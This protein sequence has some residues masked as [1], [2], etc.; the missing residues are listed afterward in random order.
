MHDGLRDGILADLDALL[1]TGGFANG[2][3]V[4]EFEAAYADYNEATHCVGVANGLDGLRLSLQGLDIGRGDEVIVPA[5]TFVATWEAVSQVGATPVPVDV[6]PSDYCMSID[7]AAAAVTSRTRCLLPVDL[8]GQLGDLAALRQLADRH[9]L[10]LVEDACQ[11]HG[12]RRDGRPAGAFAHAAASS[13]YPGKNLGAIGDAGA[14][15]TGDAT[16]AARLRLLR[17]HGQPRKYAHAEIGWTSRLDTLQAAVLLRKLP[18]LDGWNDDR[19]AV[20]ATLRA[21]LADTGDLVLPPVAEGSDPVWHLF[22]VLTSEPDRLVQSLARAGIGCGR[23]YPQPPH[24]TEAYAELGYSAG[25]FPVAERI[26]AGCVSLPIFPGMTAAEVE[27]VV[28]GVRA[29]F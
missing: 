17:E 3:Q 22:V 25:A 13:F 10:A 27:A 28:E 12:A 20:A 6:G 26:A 29:A 1:T 15:T 4:A 19:R 23:H 5:Q 14:V 18:L 24:L 21:E 9:G 8:Y 2:P 16:L 11:A 7:A